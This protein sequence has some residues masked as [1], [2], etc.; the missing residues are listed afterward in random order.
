VGFLQLRPLSDAMDEE[1]EMPA[2]AP[3][4]ILCESPSVLGHGRSHAIRDLI[5]VD[6]EQFQRSR[7]VD[8][9]D[10][11]A[12]LN[13]RLV[14]EDRPYALVGVGRWGSSQPWLGIPVRWED[15]SGA[16]VIVEAALGDQGVQPS[17][18]THFFQ[19]LVSLNIG[20]FT[21]DEAGGEGRIDWDWLRAV[22]PTESEGAARLLRFDVP[23]EVVIDGRA[24]RGVMLK[25]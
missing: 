22:E 2:V 16:R 25:P 21:I 11:V 12:R 9:A 17:Q 4:R 10:A 14:R 18:G 23:L 7:S 6:P 1:V 8:C 15:I 13:A 24:R 20:Y 5:V 19:N 3:G